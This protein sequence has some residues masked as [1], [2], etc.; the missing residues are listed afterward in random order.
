MKHQN[1]DL[2][3]QGA[4]KTDAAPTNAAGQALSDEELDNVSGGMVNELPSTDNLAAPITNQKKPTLE[5]PLNRENI[6]LAPYK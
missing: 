3:Q 5:S 6:I 4:A 2:T 1:E